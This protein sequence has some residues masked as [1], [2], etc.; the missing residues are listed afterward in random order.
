MRIPENFM[1]YGHYIEVHRMPLEKVIEC[2][3]NSV[4]PK[5]YH[6]DEDED[7]YGLCHPAQYTIYL[8]LDRLADKTDEFVLQT[9]IH[10]LMHMVFVM[11][12]EFDD[13]DNEGKVDRLAQLLTQFMT[14]KQGDLFDELDKPT[15]EQ[16]NHPY[17]TR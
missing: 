4:G 7:F 11:A 13:N 10:E 17:T 9:F 1:L 15:T 2:Y 6:L 3:N 5:K 12:G 16:D 8:C 14:T